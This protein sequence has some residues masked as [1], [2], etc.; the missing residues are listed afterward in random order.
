MNVSRPPAPPTRRRIS[1]PRVGVAAAAGLAAA[2]GV[3]RFVFTPLLPIMTS[4]AGI[5]AGDGAIIATGNY[6]GYLVGAVLLTRMPHLSRR[7]TFLAWS[8]VLI[9]SEAAMALSAQVVPQ[10]GLRFAA[11]VASAAIFIACASTVARHR[12][13]GASMGVAFAGVGAGIAITGVFT[14]AAGTWLSWQGLWVGSA[15]LT[16]V[17]LAPAWMLDIRDETDADLGIDPAVRARLDPNVRRAW[18]LLLSA[19]FAEGLGYI[20]LGTFLVA[21]V[22]GHGGGHSSTGALL[23]TLVGV[24]AVPATMIWHAVAR[25]IGTGRALVAALVIQCVGTAAPA[26]SDSVIAALIAAVTF[27][28]TF[29]AIVMLAVDAG[30]RL[31]VPRSAAT[32]TAAFAVGQM[33]GP[34]IVA[35]V[36]ENSYD[37]AFAIAAVIVAVSAGLAAA[38]TRAMDSIPDSARTPSPRSSAGRSSDQL[39]DLD[40]S[41]PGRSVADAR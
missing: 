25:R 35:P 5:S 24:A 37:M 38:A 33:I 10:A 40:R 22:A 4:S 9:A 29:M 12:R 7:S 16:A 3:G 20:I 31:P 19:Y 27:G 11:G 14:L 36:I 32:L 2:M 13:E 6:A 17:L 41:L 39:G 26:V 8:V 23:W 18:L 1:G 34:L 21:A 28:A 30:N 15:V